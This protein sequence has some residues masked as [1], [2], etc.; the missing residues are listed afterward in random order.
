MVDSLSR[1]VKAGTVARIVGVHGNDVFFDAPKNPMRDDG[2]WTLGHSL[3]V[4][5]IEHSAEKVARVA[6]MAVSSPEP[7]DLE[8]FVKL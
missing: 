4:E 6:R 8:G 1:G 7:W 5:V 3:A 2:G